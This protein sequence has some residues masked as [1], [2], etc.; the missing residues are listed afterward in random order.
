L[1][2]NEYDANFNTSKVHNKLRV[3]TEGLIKKYVQLKDSVIKKIIIVKISHALS[4]L[5]NVSFFANLTNL[6]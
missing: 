5:E 4:P 6:L 1:S 2:E 3:S